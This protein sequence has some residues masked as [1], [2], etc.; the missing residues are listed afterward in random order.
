ME[1]PQEQKAADIAEI[2]ND[3]EIDVVVEL[4]A[5]S[6]RPKVI[7]AA[8]EKGKTVVSANKH[9]IARVGRRLRR[10]LRHTRGVLL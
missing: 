5:A 4:I 9:L 8:L 1:I 2:V 10:R 7:L 6:S 3:P